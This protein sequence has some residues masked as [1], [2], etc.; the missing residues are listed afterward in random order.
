[1]QRDYRRDLIR[2]ARGGNNGSQSSRH[3]TEHL[4]QEKIK[5]LL[6]WGLCVQIFPIFVLVEPDGIC[7]YCNKFI[8]GN[9]IYQHRTL[10]PLLLAIDKN[11]HVFQFSSLLVGF[12]LGGKFSF[13]L[14]HDSDS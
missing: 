6:K 11:G 9:P 3:V 4:N 5:Q 8:N 7:I 2:S 1:M 10:D 13:D 14:R 12:F